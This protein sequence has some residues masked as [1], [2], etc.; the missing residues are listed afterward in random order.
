V[1]NW[2]VK[3]E[4]TWLSLRP[5]GGDRFGSTGAVKRETL[6]FRATILFLRNV[7]TAARCHNPEDKI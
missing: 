7:V 4:T 5:T 6:V 2:K 1:R 3:R